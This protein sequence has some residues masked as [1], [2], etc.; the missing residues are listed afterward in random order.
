MEIKKHASNR[1]KAHYNYK[2]GLN[3]GI[4]P[5]GEQIKEHR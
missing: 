1:G 3:A 5:L 4:I 2:A